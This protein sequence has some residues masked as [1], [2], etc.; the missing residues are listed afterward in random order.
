MGQGG[1]QAHFHGFDGVRPVGDPVVSSQLRHVVVA[2]PHGAVGLLPDDDAQ[3]RSSAMLGRLIIKAVPTAGL[4]KTRT[5]VGRNANPFFLAEAAWSILRDDL[6][7]FR[8]QKLREAVGGRP[9]RIAAL[10]ALHHLRADRRTEL[11]VK[12]PGDARRSS[13]RSTPS[14]FARP[15]TVT[16]LSRQSAQVAGESSTFPRMSHDPRTP[17]NRQPQ[18]PGTTVPSFS[19]VAW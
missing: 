5:S 3:R 16:Q 1:G 18:C 7:A 12:R 2:H 10:Q 6:D 15:H 17:R 19:V 4:P 14:L 8:P 9:D 13:V 11:V